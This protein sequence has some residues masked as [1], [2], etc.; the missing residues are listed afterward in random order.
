[1]KTFHY[2]T[3]FLSGKGRR[4][5]ET[6]GLRGL[7]WTRLLDLD[8]DDLLQHKHGTRKRMDLNITTFT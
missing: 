7:L 3:V 2:L 5:V 4:K 8:D 1:M 6:T